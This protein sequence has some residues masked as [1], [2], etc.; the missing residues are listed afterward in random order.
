M[1]FDIL[2]L[3]I[4]DNQNYFDEKLLK[5]IVVDNYERVQTV[6]KRYDYLGPHLNN[7]FSYLQFYSNNR[8]SHQSH[9]SYSTTSLD[10]SN[11][12]LVF[13]IITVLSIVLIG[14]TFIFISLIRRKSF[15][16][17]EFLKKQNS[18]STSSDLQTQS[19]CSAMNLFKS[20]PLNNDGKRQNLRISNRYDYNGLSSPSSLLILNNDSTNPTSLINDNCC[21]LE[22]LNEKDLYD[23]Q[24]TKVRI[25]DD[26]HDIFSI[27]LNEP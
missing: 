4:V 17:K 14:I 23:E 24:R 25:F 11:K 22:K 20:S 15:Q 27:I 10:Q 8:Q 7:R 18:L 3:K 9:Q 6:V 1:N 12:F 21:L 2:C 19:D 26:I 5:L 16:Q 13:I